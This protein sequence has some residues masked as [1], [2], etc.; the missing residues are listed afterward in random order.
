[1]EFRC[2][3][4]GFQLASDKALFIQYSPG[5]IRLMKCEN[6]KAVADE[7]IECEIMGLFWKSISA[8]LLLDAFTIL[9]LNWSE[10]NWSLSVS[11]SS[12]VLGCTKMLMNLLLRNFMFLCILLLAN[13]YFLDAHVGVSRCTD[14]L[15]AIFVSSYLKIFLITMLVW[16][17]PY[18]V[19]FIIDMFVL[20]SNVVALKAVMTES[21]IGKCIGTCFSAHA[22][23]WLLHF[24]C[25][26]H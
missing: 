17:F 7:Y 16:E 19:L 12:L 25:Q 4:C 14:I 13:R 9:V 2:V 15:F 11:F 20:S 23:K 5:N 22:V 21:S 24:I 8:F 6:C 10:E 3:E 18:S 1:M 26:D